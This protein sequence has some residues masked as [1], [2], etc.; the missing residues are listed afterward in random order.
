VG[1]QTTQT[2]RQFVE[3]QFGIT[4]GMLFVL[5]TLMALVGGIGL[6]G[7]LSISVVERTR[8]IGVMRAIG[9]KT[10]MLLAMFIMEGLLQGLLSWA[11]SW[12]ISFVLGRPLTQALGKALEVKLDYQYSF[13]AVLYWLGV[14]LL[15]SSLASLIPARNAIRISVRDSLAYT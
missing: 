13:T 1:A 14:I 6:M 15:I 5:A 9:A 3:S 2:F 10:P 8:E 11:I 12:P 7:S 4:I